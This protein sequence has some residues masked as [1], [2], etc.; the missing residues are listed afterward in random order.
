MVGL[1]EISLVFIPLGLKQFPYEL[2]D[3]NTYEFF[4]HQVVRFIGLNSIGFL[5]MGCFLVLHS[6][7]IL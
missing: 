1:N 6:I 5:G 2:E 7:G 4:F 3:Y